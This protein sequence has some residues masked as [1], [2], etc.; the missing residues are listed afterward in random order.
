MQYKLEPFQQNEKLAAAVRLA[1][2]DYLVV[3]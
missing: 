3:D 1:M 2:A